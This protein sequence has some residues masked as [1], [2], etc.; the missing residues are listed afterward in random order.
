MNE[1]QNAVKN[2]PKKE[3]KPVSVRQIAA[4]AVV[5]IL[6]TGVDLGIQM[7]ILSWKGEDG[8]VMAEILAFLVTCIFSFCGFHLAVFRA[9][10]PSGLHWLAAAVSFLTYAL[11]AFL[12]A[13]IVYGKLSPFLGTGATA[14][15]CFGAVY[16]GEYFYLSRRTFHK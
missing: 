11:G 4:F 12:I 1:E 14:L 3:K 13:R 10:M 9:E 15:L 8:A 2:Q 6:A 5:C 16:I 7:G